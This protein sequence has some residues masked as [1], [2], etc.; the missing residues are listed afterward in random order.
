MGVLNVAAARGPL[1]LVAD[2]LPPSVVV[3]VPTRVPAASSSMLEMPPLLL[4]A[5]R[6]SRLFAESATTTP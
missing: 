3:R 6:R 1:A 2:P 4:E 5:I